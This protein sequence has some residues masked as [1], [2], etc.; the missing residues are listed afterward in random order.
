[1]PRRV[2]FI[3]AV[4][5][6]S[7]AYAQPDYIWWEGESP[8]NTNFPDHSAFSPTNPQE[9]AKLSG[10]Q[11]LS[12]HRE[13]GA[14]QP[15]AFAEYDV[16]VEKA[17]RYHLWARKFWKHG[18][19]RWRFDDQPWQSCGRDVA[20]A[21]SV[22]LRT[23]VVANWVYLGQANLPAGKRR[24]RFELLAE[25]G[26]KQTS[27]FDCFVLTAGVFVPNGKLKPGEK[28]DR[29]DEGFFAWEPGID[30][31]AESPIDLRYLNEQRAGIH[32]RLRAKG[33]GLVTGDGKP[34]RLWGV[35]VNAS[36]AGQT[37]ASIDY[38]ARKLAKMGVNAVRYHGPL[39]DS[40]D[41][42]KLD[43][44]KLD[45]LHY[46]IH[47]MAQQGIYTKVS[48]YFPLWFDIKPEY[49]I[50]GYD[51][52]GNKRPFGLLFFDPRMQAIHR[53]WLRQLLA[54]PNPYSGQPIGK[55]P[56]VAIIE[57][58]NEDSLLFWTFSKKNIPKVHWQRLEAMFA[59]SI[60]KPAGQAKLREAWFM[61]GAGYASQ[62]RSAQAEIRRQVRF[63]VE[64][65]RRFY[66]DTAKFMRDDCGYPGLISASNWKTAD[67]RMLGALERYTYT[68]GDVIDRHGS[69]GGR[70]EGEGSHYSVRVGHRYEDRAGVKH[71]MELPITDQQ[72]AGRPH[73][74]SEVGWPNPNVYRGEAT[75][76][77]A[78]YLSLQGIDGVFWFAV[79]SNLLDDRQITKFAVSDPATAWTFTA[80]AL[81]YR[82][83]YVSEAPVVVRE[84]LALDDLYALRGSAAVMAE[85][86][87]S[88]G[89]AM[90]A[91]RRY[92]HPSVWIP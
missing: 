42:M 57:I 63:L 72:I 79:G 87:I 24:F 26:Q 35:N 68:A 71:P 76:L 10:G 33:E 86:L 81:I 62:S 77:G 80:N 37:R 50:E 84:T 51:T 92:A 15:A 13:R 11:W 38:L 64:L 46:L 82:K 91:V 75:A 28:F 2:C 17:G 66:A 83:A 12:D 31:F 45:D 40:A 73:I 56:A 60:G 70:H 78:A 43:A 18:P 39:F 88:C 49:G 23:H 8:A 89:R 4:W 59:K 41:V 85:A 54:T 74:I 55:D 58:V 25:A 34:V 44:K 52:I 7:A 32:G 69:F 16:S 21:D 30:S 53:S 67:E 61:T 48:F 1:M 6:A 5:M 14:D 47:A 22:T 3:V 20:L 9:V 27:A 36:N 90:A 65:Q 19:F 29:A